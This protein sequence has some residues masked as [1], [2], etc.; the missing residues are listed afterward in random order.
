MNRK[1]PTV[2]KSAIEKKAMLKQLR[3]GSK[4]KTTRC[5]SVRG[6]LDAARQEHDLQ[7]ED[8]I[9]YQSQLSSTRA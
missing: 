4:T 8:S 5:S 1:V 9:F 2:V 6:V 3:G 7:H